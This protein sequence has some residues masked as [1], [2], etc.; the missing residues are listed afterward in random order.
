MNERLKVLGEQA[1][2]LSAQDRVALVE[3]L[4]ESL[5]QTDPGID[6]LWAREAAQRLAAYRRGDISAK[7]INDIVAKH[8]S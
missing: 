7:E 6:A 5:D 8:R 2:A 4:L 3:H 1:R